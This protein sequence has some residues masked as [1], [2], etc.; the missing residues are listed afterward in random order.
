MPARLKAL[1]RVLAAHG[2]DLERP[3]SGSHWKFR[4]DSETYPV[5]APN[6]TRS[7]ISDIYI[8]GLCRTFGVDYDELLKEL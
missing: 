6:G 3:R 1:A 2:V 5:P 7:E 8:R 4:T